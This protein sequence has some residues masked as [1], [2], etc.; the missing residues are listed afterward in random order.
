MTDKQGASM[1]GEHHTYPSLPNHEPPFERLR[2]LVADDNL[3][4]VR[5]TALLL[6]YAGFEV[7]TAS[8]GH[9]ALKVA[10]EFHPQIALLDVGLPGID[11]Y[12]VVRRLR[13]DLTLQMMTLIAITAYGTEEDRHRA[14]A[15]G[16]DHHLVKPVHF[17]NLLSVMGPQSRPRGHLQ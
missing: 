17:Y 6:Q 5:T 7:R 2:V 16:F 9:D 1:V 15:A 14:K 11:G 3:A 8:N 4:I 12:E 13:A 10:R